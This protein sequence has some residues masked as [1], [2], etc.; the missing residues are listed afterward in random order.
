MGGSADGTDGPSDKEDKARL[1]S[2]VVEFTL[3]KAPTL[4]KN[5]VEPNPD[6]P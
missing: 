3:C 5:G 1:D 2:S 4:Q 6:E